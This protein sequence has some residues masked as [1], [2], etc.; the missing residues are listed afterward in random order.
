[1]NIQVAELASRYGMSEKDFQNVLKEHLEALNDDGEHVKFVAKKWSIDDSV[2]GILD[3]LLGYVPP[4]AKSA[5][6]GDEKNEKLVQKLTCENEKLSQ[7]LQSISSSF[8]K[9]KR[10]NDDLQNQFLGI[11][12]G[13]E[14]INSGL[15]RKY[16]GLAESAQK[17]L[18]QVK[19]DLEQVKN[20]LD[21][22]I[23]EK[24]QQS[25]E[26]QK[27]IAELHA[28]LQKFQKAKLETDF[29]LVE[30]KKQ[31]EKLFD[32]LNQSKQEYDSLQD[33]LS[34]VQFEKDHADKRISL[35]LLQIKQAINIVQSAQSQLTALLAE[36][37][38]K[39]KQEPQSQ[40]KEK[41]AETF[42]KPI[43]TEELHQTIEA[44]KETQKKKKESAFHRVAGFFGFL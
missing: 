43:S 36:S 32:E 20:R 23:S 33:R 37:D 38:S 35:M 14:A 44:Q 26:A 40:A 12:E 29:H 22:V 16:K 3:K 34:N 39:V 5:P 42:V 9:L 13:R 18:E 28:E 41:S 25:A 24:N 2:L 27:R 15:V 10:E 21:A 17:D 7:R 1:M 11:Q 4:E 6:S 30:A 19:K 8:E 31:Q